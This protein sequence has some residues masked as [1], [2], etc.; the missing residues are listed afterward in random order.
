MTISEILSDYIDS[1]IS[2]N[3][4][5]YNGWYVG[6]TADT[7]RRL[8]DEH[9]VDLSDG[10][11]KCKEASSEYQA[12]LSEQR[13]IEMGCQGGTGGGKNATWVYVYRITAYTVE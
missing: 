5:S 2:V 10:Y 9:K 12:R 3:G 11:Y 4:G 7:H 1:Y 13:L 6:V 8:F